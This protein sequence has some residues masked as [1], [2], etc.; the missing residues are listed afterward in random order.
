MASRLILCTH[1]GSQVATFVLHCESV[2]WCHV[3]WLSRNREKV[4]VLD[5]NGQEEVDF[6]SCNNFTDATALS[7]A[8]NHN[9]LS[10]QLVK[11]SAISVKEAVWV[12]GGWIF[13]LLTE[14]CKQRIK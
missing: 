10:L 7:H 1:G 11:L 12:E 13:P 3:Q 14:V 8:E 5:E 6:I 2:L 9:L 4:Q